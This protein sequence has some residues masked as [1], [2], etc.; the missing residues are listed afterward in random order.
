MNLADSIKAITATARK[1]HG[2]DIFIMVARAATFGNTDNL[3][4]V[5]GANHAAAA[6]DFAKVIKG[7]T[8]GIDYQTRYDANDNPIEGQGIPYSTVQWGPDA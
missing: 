4:L 2:P 1:V 5:Q 3:V 8:I 7:C 6:R